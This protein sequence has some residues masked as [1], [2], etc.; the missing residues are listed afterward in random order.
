MLVHQNGYSR[1][2]VKIAEVITHPE[3]Q[4]TL[5]PSA[6]VLKH[7]QFPS[8]LSLQEECGAS[9][10]LDRVPPVLVICEV[11]EISACTRVAFYEGKL[12]GNN[13]LSNALK[14]FTC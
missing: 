9:A 10:Q 14:E 1:S 3:I 7:L 4:N 12:D 8:Q 5:Q 2:F 6:L 11:H 13:G